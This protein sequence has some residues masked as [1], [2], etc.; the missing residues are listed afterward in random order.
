MTQA[1]FAQFDYNPQ[2][3]KGIQKGSAKKVKEDADRNISNFNFESILPVSFFTL[4]VRP[5]FSSDSRSDSYFGVVKTMTLNE[6]YLPN[7]L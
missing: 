7:I 6:V 3:T 5:R 4:A 2:D 1:D